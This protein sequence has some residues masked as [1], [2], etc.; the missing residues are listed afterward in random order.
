MKS[1]QDGACCDDL[2]NGSVRGDDVGSDKGFDRDTH[3]IDSPLFGTT[4]RKKHRQQHFLPN[5][6]H[7]YISLSLIHT[8]VPYLSLL[9][10]LIWLQDLPLP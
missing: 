2:A 5:Y 6:C 8:V 9:M 7:L 4:S 3:E 10:N 1:Y